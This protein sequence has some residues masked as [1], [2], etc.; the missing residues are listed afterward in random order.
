LIK[1]AADLY[2]LT[3]EQ[4]MPLDRMGERKA[5][6][7]LSSIATVKKQT[8]RVFLLSLGIEALGKDVSE[9]IA[10]FVDFETMEVTTDITTID[11]IG[12]STAKSVLDGLKEMKW[13]AEELKKHV[14]IESKQTVQLGNTL[15]GKS[16]CVSGHVE[17]IFK[18][19]DTYED[20]E[21]IQQLIKNY[22]GRAVSSVSKKLDFLVAGPGS[23]SKSDKANEYGVPII[24]GADLV[25]MMEG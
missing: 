12:D 18:N 24:T 22:G 25:K 9:K 1:N 13:F 21:A 2:T 11:G 10:D 19:N 4:L 5:E 3:K 15:N 16:F 8:P 7:V 14:T 23:G 20:R 17:L 6:N